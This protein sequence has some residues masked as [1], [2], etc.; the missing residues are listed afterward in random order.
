ML[1]LN[2]Y[3]NVLNIS[4][5]RCMKLLFAAVIHDIKI[6][7]ANSIHGWQGWFSMF[8]R[9]NTFHTSCSVCYVN[10]QCKKYRK[11][12]HRYRTKWYHIKRECQRIKFIAMW[13]ICTIWCLLILLRPDDTYMRQLFCSSLMQVIACGL[14]GA[15]PLSEPMCLNII[16]KCR[17]HFWGGL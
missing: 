16:P 2:N 8:C 5:K 4:N 9:W 3:I 17:L 15:K 14:F 11:I 10:G 1:R 12:K 7:Y 6:R 13:P